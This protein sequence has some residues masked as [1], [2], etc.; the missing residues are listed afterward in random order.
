MRE[1]AGQRSSPDP[2]GDLRRESRNTNPFVIIWRDLGQEGREKS[3]A[4][5]NLPWEMKLKRGKE[6]IHIGSEARSRI[7][8]HHATPR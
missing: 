1:V 7:P 5:E 4:H 8:S 2:G 3:P 6:K